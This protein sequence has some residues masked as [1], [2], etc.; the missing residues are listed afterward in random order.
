MGKY[1]K[2][3]VPG[4]F[5]YVGSRGATIYGISYRSGG[6]KHREIVGPLLGEARAKL[7]EVHAM[8][9]SGGFISAAAQRKFTF[10]ELA[11]KYEENQAAAYLQSSKRYFVK[12][13][14]DHF[15]E[16]TLS[17]ITPLEIETFKRMRKETPTLSRR[18]RSDVA[19]NRELETLRHM[20]NRAVL[21]KM[22]AKSPFDEFSKAGVR[23]FFEERN[24]RCRYLKEE[25][26]QRLLTAC[27]AYLRNVVQG[28]L[29]TGLN[30]I[31]D[32]A[33]HKGITNA[34]HSYVSKLSGKSDPDHNK[35]NR[36]TAKEYS[37]RYVDLLRNK[38]SKPYEKLVAYQGRTLPWDRL[39]PPEKS[40]LL[41]KEGWDLTPGAFIEYS[42]LGDKYRK[43]RNEYPIE[44]TLWK[45]DEVFEKLLQEIG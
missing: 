20:L 7:E 37:R 13:L 38:Y 30:S 24:D 32:L 3:H 22:L 40:R 23:I 27:P 36:N 29:L 2:T 17:Q 25:E 35:E 18:P 33:T 21:W 41:D 8:A 31:Q 12:A 28:A 19:V 45:T 15:G 26:I 4:I 16:K 42:S 6:R 39:L 44:S 34:Q 10:A 9:K 14:L 1:L 43:I 5:K 11:K